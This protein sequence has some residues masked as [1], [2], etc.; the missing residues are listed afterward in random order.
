MALLELSV[1]DVN[2]NGVYTSLVQSLVF[3]EVTEGIISWPETLDIRLPFK[4]MKSEEMVWVRCDV[5]Y[6]E[7]VTRRE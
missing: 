5:D 6:L 2:V 1:A 3:R 4:L 7:V